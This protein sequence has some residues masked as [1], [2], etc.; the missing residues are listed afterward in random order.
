[1]TETSCKRDLLLSKRRN[2]IVYFTLVL[3][4]EMKE[5][6]ISYYPFQIEADT[7]SQ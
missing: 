3:I 7:G 2:G 1:M 5:Y 4:A 6:I